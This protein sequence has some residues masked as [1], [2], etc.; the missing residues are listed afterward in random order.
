MRRLLV[1]LA[2][3]ATLTACG[4]AASPTADLGPLAD[5]ADRVADLIEQDRPCEATEALRTLE[6]MADGEFAPQVREAVVS[7]AS[8]AQQT[9]TCDPA[10]EPQE[11]P[12]PPEDPGRDDGKGKGNGKAKGKDK[13]DDD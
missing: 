9:V 1:L 4:G 5:Q 12:P 10:A 8:T 7:F 11:P 13:G 2:L 3:A 6:S